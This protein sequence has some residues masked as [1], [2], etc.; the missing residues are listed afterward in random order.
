MS[1]SDEKYRLKLLNISLLVPV[2]QLSASVFQEINTII[3]RKNEPKS[4]GIHYRR[5]EVR[6]ISL[7][8]NKEE[9]NSDGLFTDC[10]L[11]CKIVIC[12]VKTASKVGDYQTNPFDFCRKWEV[13]STVSTTDFEKSD[14]EKVL[15]LRIKEI[16]EKFQKFQATFE[17]KN[18]GKG[19]KSKKSST[20]N[21]TLASEINKEAEKR[22]RSFLESEQSSASSETGSRNT[23]YLPSAPP[24]EASEQG[25]FINLKIR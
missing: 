25:Q 24:Y 4:V 11:P 2:A 21:Q 23:S 1:V 22:L 19:P 12:F 9:Y 8:R 3:T 15:E 6:P 5:I 20:Q 13:P 7:P 17:A 14:R 10:D 16:E 18:K